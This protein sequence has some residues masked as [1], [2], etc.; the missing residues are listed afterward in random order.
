MQRV[1]TSFLLCLAFL[2]LLLPCLAIAVIVVVGLLLSST[3]SATPFL[4]LGIRANSKGQ[5]QRCGKRH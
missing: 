2:A 1:P 3:V 4:F 5:R